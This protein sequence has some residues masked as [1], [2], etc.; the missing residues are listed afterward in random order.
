MPL[1]KGTK[2]LLFYLELMMTI[3]FRSII[4]TTFVL[5]LF[6][7]LLKGG[8]AQSAWAVEYTDYTSAEGQDPTNQ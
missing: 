1:N 2:L 7:I 5:P 3:F 8:V 6:I 4:C